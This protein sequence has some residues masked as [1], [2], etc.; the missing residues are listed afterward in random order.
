[1]TSLHFSDGDRRPAD[2][3]A[4]LRPRR[5]IESWLATFDA[6]LLEVDLSG[7]TFFEPSALRAFLSSSPQPASA[8]R[9]RRATRG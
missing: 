3:S 2:D 1:V 5:D 6:Q 7:V 8:H 9:W 4:R